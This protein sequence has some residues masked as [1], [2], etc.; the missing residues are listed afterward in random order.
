LGV[1]AAQS[2]KQ[3]SVAPPLTIAGTVPWSRR[4]PDSAHLEQRPLHRWQPA[5]PVER[6]E[7]TRALDQHK[8]RDACASRRAGRIDRSIRARRCNR[9]ASN[10][11]RNTSR[12]RTKRNAGRPAAQV[13]RSLQE[14]SLAT[15]ERQ[16]TPSAQ[17]CT[18]GRTCGVR[19][20]TEQVNDEHASRLFVS[21]S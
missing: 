20:P 4:N 19:G 17:Q 18:A 14:K 15:A 1:L 3:D 13:P 11:R 16:E 8:P 6:R 12:C 5:T 10:P 9:T 21:D 7:Q 2:T